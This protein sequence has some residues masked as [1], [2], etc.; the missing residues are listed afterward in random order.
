MIA[1]TK[2]HNVVSYNHV[3]TDEKNNIA[4]MM[5]VFGGL[6]RV[7]RCCCRDEA[8]CADVTFHQF[9]ILD[10][11]AKQKEISLAD[12]HKFLSVEKSTTTRLVAPLIG[13]GLLQRE[14][15]DHDSRAVKL[16]LTPKGRKTYRKVLICLENFFRKSCAIFRPGKDGMCWSR[17]KFSSWPS[18]ILKMAGGVSWRKE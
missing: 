1:L 14:K 7:L 12:L 18:K 10:A 5:E 6:S 2:S 13:K 4:E 11:I 9:L 15:A 17:S 16:L 8:F 3:C